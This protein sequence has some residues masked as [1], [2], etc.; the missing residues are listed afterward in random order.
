MRSD[1]VGI[2]G[3]IEHPP[4]PRDDLRQRRHVGKAHRHVDAVLVRGRNADH[5]AMAA[6]GDGAPVGVSPTRVRRREWRARR[7][8]TA[9][10]PS[11]MAAGRR[12]APTAC[13]L[14]AANCRASAAASPAA[15]PNNCRKVSLKRRTLLKPEASATSRHRQR[16]LVD[17]LLC[18]QHPPRLRDRDRRGADMLA[19]Q[20]AQLPR[21]D[22]EPIGSGLRHRRRRARRPRS[23][24][25]RATP[26]WRCRARTPAPARFPAGSAGRGESPPP[27]PPRRTHRTTRSRISACAPGRSAG[28]RCRWS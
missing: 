21:A 9:S 22:A 26:C 18:Q 4:H 15:R 27:A 28:S 8:T 5:A 6:D 13:R 11:H 23:A 24:P 1:G 7:E 12:A 2:G 3:E 20:P 10:R 17:Q 25:A 14:R 19:E 16:R